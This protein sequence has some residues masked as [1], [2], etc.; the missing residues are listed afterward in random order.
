MHDRSCSGFSTLAPGKQPGRICANFSHVGKKLRIQSGIDLPPGTSKWNKIEHRLTTRCRQS[1]S[2]ATISTA[3]G[4]IPFHL[5]NNHLE[6]VIFAQALSEDR[7]P[8]GSC[9]RFVHREHCICDQCPR[10]CSASWP[11]Q[12]YCYLRTSCGARLTI[13]TRRG[14]AGIVFAGQTWPQEYPQTPAPARECSA[15]AAWSAGHR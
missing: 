3:S 4:I 8:I 10:R 1:T 12:K 11:N 15:M 9:R 5:T 7:G 13:R 6:A 14:G 2:C